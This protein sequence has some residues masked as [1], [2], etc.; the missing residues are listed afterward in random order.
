MR[1]QKTKYFLFGLILTLLVLPTIEQF[2]S[3]FHVKPLNGDFVLVEKPSFS[4]TGWLSGI[5][6]TKFDK[7]LEDHIGFRNF[8]VRLNNQVEFSLFRKANAEGVVVGKDRQ[9]YESDYIRAYTGKDFIGTKTIDKKMRRLKFLQEYL[10][11]E[12]NINLILVFEPSKARFY[13][14]CIPD[15]FLNDSIKISN[16]ECFTQKA[17][18]LGITFIDFNNY[19]RQIKDTSKYLLYPKYGIHWSIYGMS[20][21]ADSL[22]RF[23]EDLRGIDMPDMN[24]KNIE[25]SDELRYT[26]YDVGKTLNL[27]W[28]LPHPKMAYPEFSF[29]KND[30]K[31]RPH[32]LA[33]ADSYY[34]NIFN[35]RLPKNLFANEAFWY[36][37]A[38][39][40]PDFYLEEK[41]VKDI[42]LK[43]EIEK[44]D[45]ILLMITER[46]L[47]KY[48]WGFIDNVYELYTPKYT[49]DIVYDFENGIRIH[50]VWFEKII[51][52]AKKKGV[53]LSEMIHCE[54]EYRAIIEDFE[55][56]LSWYGMDYYMDL[57]RK[58]TTWSEVV[59]EK[60][61]KNNLSFEEMLRRDAEYV[62]NSDYPKIKKKYFLI[63]EIENSIRSDS[64]WFEN[65]T[66]KAGYFY[67]EPKD[68]IKIDAEYLANI[69]LQKKTGREDRIQFYINMIKDDPEWMKLVQAK[70]IERGKSLDEM[71]RDDAEYMVE[72]EKR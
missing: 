15:R 59:M 22:I 62:F 14:E 6:Q 20:L 7:Y 50:A 13:P 8:F 47:F 39:V 45:I 18:E 63:K 31:T 37:N 4:W 36:F 9:L 54:A 25:L 32:V 67:L 55:T 24:I 69:Q 34:W 68:M 26:D 1:Y 12:K 60:A 71:I 61:V 27:L 35:T 2:T 19:F 43:S 58:D 46:F 44:Q 66:K 29:E 33:V 28:Q 3:L 42:D 52:N 16:Y 30:Q 56:Y 72:Q 65:V 57:I 21:V 48:D 23:M 70:A 49:G 53:N 41:W 40:Y 5:Y 38:K 17:G 11:K 10:K 51:D 64:V